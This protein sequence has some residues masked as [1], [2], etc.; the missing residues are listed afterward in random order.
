MKGS[1][2]IGSVAGIQIGIHY[3]WI[4]AFFLFAWSLAAGFFPQNYPGWSQTAYW[5]TGFIGSFMIFVSVLIHEIA[6]SLVARSRG[7]PVKSIV[8]FIFG[9]VS[10]IEKEP[11]KPGVEFLMSVVGPVSSLVLGGIFLLFWRTVPDSQG[12]LAASLFYLG[13][14]NILLGV[15]N[16]I[17]GFPLDGG[18]VLRSIIWGA[19][20]S[21]TKATNIASTTGQIFGWLF[22][23]FGVYQVFAGNLL[24]GIWIA[25]IGWFLSSSAEASRRDLTLREALKGVSV[26]EVM[27]SNPEVVHPETPI[28]TL[29]HDIF[30]QH[31]RRAAPV[32]SNDRIVGIM[33]LT[34][35]KTIPQDQWPVTPVERVMKK[36]PI[37]YV[38][39]ED[40][41]SKAMQMISDNG[42]NQLLVLKEGR[43][44]GLI[45]RADIIRYLQ[46]HQ[47]LGIQPRTGS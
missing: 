42:L 33:T 7:L 2:N 15:F 21:L 23:A 30:L 40:D 46:M 6:H 4:L 32:C 36:E 16:I 43:L 27:D 39:M 34:D 38:K 45:S 9:G 26:K 41:L 1:F 18:R 14:I 8:L 37:Y 29:V 3:T 31:G 25:F 44:V 11:E 5:V 19:T 12:P 13:S 24:G 10:N 22:I 35:V 17:P 20:G 47:E 28:S